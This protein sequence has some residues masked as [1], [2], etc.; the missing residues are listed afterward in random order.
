M[1]RERAGRN[2]NLH[3]EC[4]YTHASTHNE[5]EREREERERREREDIRR[6]T[7]RLGE[8]RRDSKRLG[9]ERERGER[10]EREKRFHSPE[11]TDTLFC[12]R[13]LAAQAHTIP[14]H[15][16]G[17]ATT[18]AVPSPRFDEGSE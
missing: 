2:L 13:L 6:D 15:R 4:K 18:V 16:P 9:D 8:T 12:M 7:E 14:L 3:E 1:S 5:R 10:E 11:S 17:A